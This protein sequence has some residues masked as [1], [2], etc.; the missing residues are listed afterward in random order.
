MKNLSNNIIKSIRGKK[1]I[2]YESFFYNFKEH[3]VGKLVWRC[4]KRGCP[5]LLKT[6]I[7]CLLLEFSE[8]N[9]C[10]NDIKFSKVL[11][12]SKLKQRIL[13]TSETSRVAISNVISEFNCSNIIDY[14]MMNSLVT[15][16]RETNNLTIVRNMIFHTN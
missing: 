13:D 9:H 11:F 12:A 8:H 7:D 3:S 1:K 4:N 10:S 6:T 2:A 5:S 15:R 14:K 16:A